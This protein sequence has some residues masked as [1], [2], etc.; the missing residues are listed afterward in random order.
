MRELGKLRADLVVTVQ[1][2]QTLQSSDVIRNARAVETVNLTVPIAQQAACSQR[3][4]AGQVVQNDQTPFKGIVILFQENAAGSL[5]LGEDNTDPEGRYAII[6]T[7]PADTDSAKLRVA[8]FDADGQ[9]RAEAT[10]E[11]TR[12]VEVVNLTVGGEGKAFRV[13][14]KVASDTRPGVGGLRVVIVDKNVG[15]DV[16]VFETTTNADGNYR[17]AFTYAGQKQKPDLQVRAF[18]SEVFLGASEVRYNAANVR[19]AECTC[20]G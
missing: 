14:G 13:V 5:R 16:T 8:A 17:A 1:T 10:I 12:P 18:H 6:Y 7:L 4:V 19:D 15:G 3:T 9:R 20:A 2:E 11:A